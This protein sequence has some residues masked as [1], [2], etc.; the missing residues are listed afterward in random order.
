[1]H[2][3]L[4]LLSGRLNVLPVKSSRSSHEPI[5]MVPHCRDRP[6]TSSP[7]PRGWRPRDY[8]DHYSGHAGL[9]EDSLRYDLLPI[10][11]TH[12]H[13]FANN[14]HLT[15]HRSRNDSTRPHIHIHPSSQFIHLGPRLDE[16]SYS[17]SRSF[18][19]N[20]KCSH[21]EH[22]LR[23]DHINASLNLLCVATKLL[24]KTRASRIFIFAS[25][26]LH[27]PPCHTS[28]PAAIL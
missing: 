7:R 27:R 19:R 8:A 18:R 28:P 5:A 14:Q 15:S 10:Y 1:M 9:S 21:F 12:I 3:M 16:D 22:G 6:K 13:L 26:L 11:T 25:L 2:Q 20:I 17:V 4:W 23:T 24:S